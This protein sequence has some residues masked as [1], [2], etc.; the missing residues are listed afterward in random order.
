MSLR[1]WRWF[2]VS[3][4]FKPSHMYVGWF[5]RKS[6]RRLHLWVCVIP[7]FP[8]YFVFRVK[9]HSLQPSAIARKEKAQVP[10]PT[11]R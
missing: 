1:N 7:C 4:Q 8:V 5:W 6:D 2:S 9:H 11:D 10:P 3:L